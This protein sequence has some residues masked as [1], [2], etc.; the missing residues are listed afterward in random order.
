MPPGRSEYYQE[1]LADGWLEE[2]EEKRYVVCNG[3]VRMRWNADLGAID[4]GNYTL[5]RM[6]KI[7]NTSS[8]TSVR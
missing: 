8:S 5:R 7:H 6:E 2:E 3:D 4:D 1:L